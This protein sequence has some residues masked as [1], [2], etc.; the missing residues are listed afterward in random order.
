MSLDKTRYKRLAMGAAL[1]TG[2]KVKWGHF[3]LKVK[4]SL[5]EGGFG[6]VYLVKDKHTAKRYA[7]KRVPCQ[8]AQSLQVQ[9]HVWVW[10]GGG[11]GSVTCTARLLGM[12]CS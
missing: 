5:G 1:T 4:K 6:F 10:L 12:K 9:H 11:C 7:L 3:S 2:K 8:D